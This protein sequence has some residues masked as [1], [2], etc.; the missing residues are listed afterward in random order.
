[1][2]KLTQMPDGHI[3]II[4]KPPSQD[5]LGEL[6]D[7]IGPDEAAVVVPADEMRAFL[8]MLAASGS[9]GA[10]EPE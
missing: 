2:A 7:R 10:P 5:V 8:E 1:M 3:H 6:A 4:G 9:G